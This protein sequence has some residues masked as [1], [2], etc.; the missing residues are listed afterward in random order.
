MIYIETHLVT[1]ILGNYCAAALSWMPEDISDDTSWLVQVLAWQQTIIW[2]MST[3]LY[4]G[5][6]CH[7]GFIDGKSVL[8]RI[9]AWYRQITSNC[10]P[11]QHKINDGI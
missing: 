10:P 3:Q 2:R 9:E 8:A 5:M 4:G 6:L 11:C 7:H 1:D